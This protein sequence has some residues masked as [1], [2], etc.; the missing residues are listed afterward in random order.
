MIYILL[1][2]V[3]IPVLIFLGIQ[4]IRERMIYAFPALFL[5]GLWCALSVKIYWDDPILLASIWGMTI[6][7]YS[8]FR[9][10]SFWGAGDSDMFLLC[11]GVMM[12][13]FRITSIVQ[14]GFFICISLV[15]TQL[16]AL[17]GGWI[18]SLIKKKKL[19]R[20]SDVAVVPGF[21]VL[22]VIWIAVGIVRRGVII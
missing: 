21:S 14:Y 12:C 19:N 6:A 11:V 5:S 10:I 4:D 8:A 3:T 7:F 9:V 15:F 22:M 2:I 13:T 18:E 20:F 16:I 1:G 17:L